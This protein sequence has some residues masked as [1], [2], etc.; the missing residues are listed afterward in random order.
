MIVMIR[1]AR[2]GDVQVGIAVLQI[3]AGL[4]W[5]KFMAIFQGGMRMNDMALRGL[6]VTACALA[7]GACATG[8]ARK[9]AES[10]GHRLAMRH[11]A[12]CHAIAPGDTGQRGRAPAFASAEMRHTAGLDGRV[13]ALTRLG[14]YGMPPIPLRADE[15]SDLVNYIASLERD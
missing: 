4:V 7:L 9:E 1:S 13:A 8:A 14:H 11:C 12:A 3:R 6:L 2:A 15:V 10:P 5:N